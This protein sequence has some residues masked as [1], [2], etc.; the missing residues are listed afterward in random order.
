M[1]RRTT[2]TALE[3][4]APLTGGRAFTAFYED[5]LPAVYGYLL[6]RVAGDAATAEE[7]TQEAFV[8]AVSELRKG[9]AVE[10]P[11]AWVVGI[12][13]HKLLDHLRRAAREERAL[14][15]ASE[16]E[17]I[18]E[19]LLEPEAHDHAPRARAAL[20]VL[21]AAQRAALVLRHLE[22]LSPAEVAGAL[23][24]SL[25]ATE[26]LLARGRE[27]FKRAYMEASGD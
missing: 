17:P 8:A 14:G 15:R 4:S 18:D 23:G 6:A 3:G 13:R 10:H 26:S 11:R 7:L 27:G 24:R 21:P 1:A 22:G 12:A 2:A 25:H 5:A 9:R 16:H 19:S 20:A